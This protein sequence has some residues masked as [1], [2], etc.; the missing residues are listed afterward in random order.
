MANESYL[1]PTGQHATSVDAS[2]WLESV[3]GELKETANG[4]FT[5]HVWPYRHGGFSFIACDVMGA[6]D[7]ALGLS[8][9][10][11]SS[12]Q[13]TP[14]RTGEAHPLD[15]QMPV[16][17][18]AEAMHMISL[19]VEKVGAEVRLCRSNSAHQ[20]QREQ[21]A[22]F[23]DLD[24]EQD[25]CIPDDAPDLA[26]DEA[27]AEAAAEFETKS[28]S[29]PTFRIFHRYDLGVQDI[30]LKRVVDEIDV[31][32]AAAYVVA[33]AEEWWG[34]VLVSNLGVAAALVEFYG[35]EHV[36]SSAWYTPVDLYQQVKDFEALMSDT[37]LPRDGLKAYIRRHCCAAGPN[38]TL[39]SD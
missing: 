35:C 1:P 25:V 20:K 15:Y 12:T 9:Q 8:F 7:S 26:Y 5:V 13:E 11:V 17:D 14:A 22:S 10:I 30:F 19:L 28:L 2:Q 32:R 34:N 36:P 16:Q 18:A 38:N 31:A 6:N 37:T 21:R 24:D 29:E 33:M 39:G 3:L 4:P 27:Y 23:I